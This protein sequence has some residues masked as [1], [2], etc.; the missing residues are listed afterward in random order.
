MAAVRV[1]SQHTE[2]NEV[3]N[4]CTYG[5]QS[6][7]TALLRV[8]QGGL[9]SPCHCVRSD[10][11]AIIQNFAMHHSLQDR[12]L[13]DAP[14]STLGGLLRLLADF[15]VRDPQG[16]GMANGC[17][18]CWGASPCEQCEAVGSPSHAA[19][20]ALG[21]LAENELN[22][23]LMLRGRLEEP[24]Q[25]LLHS[26]D[27]AEELC[28]E[29]TP[30]LKRIRSHKRA[31]GLLARAGVSLNIEAFRV[32]GGL[33]DPDIVS[34]TLTESSRSVRT[35]YKAQSHVV[36]SVTE[37]RAALFVS[38]EQRLKVASDDAVIPDFVA[39]VGVH[40]GEDNSVQCALQDALA[41]NRSQWEA[42]ENSNS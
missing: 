35:T 27:V 17:L 41:L 8:V 34:T 36:R 21:A 10:A 25:V 9:A 28:V 20:K 18:V 23:S 13:L 39:E 1:L 11:T 5:S 32:P 30:L 40:I 2:F 33:S 38:Y 12:V 42:F 22:I 7:G 3:V 14:E 24:L 31:Q 6:S 19:A 29:L 26:K 15:Y 16:G 37:E 4:T